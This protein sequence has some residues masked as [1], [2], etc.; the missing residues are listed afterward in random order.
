[1]TGLIGK[2]EGHGRLFGRGT[3]FRKR[4]KKEKQGFEINSE[5]KAEVG[6]KGKLALHSGGG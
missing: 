1:M 4:R 6:K 3:N 2:K 5:E